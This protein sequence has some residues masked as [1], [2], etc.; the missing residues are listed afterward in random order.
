MNYTSNLGLIELNIPTEVVETCYHAGNC[1]DD[2]A[3]IRR[4]NADIERQLQS[5][6]QQVLRDELAEYGAW[7][8]AELADRDAN[9]NRLLWLACGELADEQANAD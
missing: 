8:D 2:I 5:V 7:D 9:L 1:S 6:N 4:T 3:Y